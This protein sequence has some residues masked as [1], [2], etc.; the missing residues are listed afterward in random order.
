[1]NF[2]VEVKVVESGKNAPNYSLDKDLNGETTLQSL[3]QFTKSALISI[4][5]QVLFE[6]QA[7]GFDKDPIVLVDGKQGKPIFNV[8]PLGKIEFLSRVTRE[9]L[10]K[11]IKD[12]YESILSR[13]PVDTGKYI[14]SHYVFINGTQVASDLLS[15]N[16]WLATKPDIGPKDLIRFVNIQPYA[17]KLERLGVTAQR[18][19][20][21]TVKSRDKRQRSGARILAP[22]GAYF[23]AF[24]SV[25]RKYKNSAGIKFSFIPGSYMGLTASFA[26][27]GSGAKKSTYLYP[28]ISFLIRDLK[29]I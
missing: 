14:S 18:Q 28:S 10:D 7:K 3:L 27:A 12:T 5:D 29:E 16:S 23:L 15:L 9:S 17:R 24:R 6:E 21:R 19:Q 22:N 2:K 13:S 26:T 4:A 11:L 8:N 1:M 25:K 20:S